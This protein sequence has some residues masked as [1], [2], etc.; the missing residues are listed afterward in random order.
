MRRQGVNCLASNSEKQRAGFSSLE[1]VMTTAIALPLAGLLF[2]LGI[3]M[4]R[5]AYSALSGLLLQPFL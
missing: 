5:Y 3:Q 2:F 1:V 4:C